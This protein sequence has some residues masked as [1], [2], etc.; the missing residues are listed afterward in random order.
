MYRLENACILIEVK[1]VVLVQI[2]TDLTAAA[3]VECT[4]AVIPAP[5]TS[6]QN[7]RYF[8]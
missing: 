3:L 2:N 8:F 5:A 4:D 7:K 1:F 6:Q